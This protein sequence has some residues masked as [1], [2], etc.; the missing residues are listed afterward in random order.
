MLSIVEARTVRGAL[1]TLPLEDI[2]NGY[3]VKEIEG[4]DPVKANVVSSSFARFD[5]SQYQSSRRESRNIKVKLGLELYDVSTSVRDLRN[6]LYQFFMPKSEVS[7]RFYDSDGLT[8]D[9]SGRVESC[10]A[11]LFSSDPQVDVSIICFDPDFTE[12]DPIVVSDVTTNLDTTNPD[13]L[14][15][16]PY[17]GTVETGVEFILHPNRSLTQFSIYHSAYLGGAEDVLD[18]AAPLSAGDTLSISTVPGAKGA[19]LIRGSTSSS[20]LYGISP[21]SAWIQLESGDNYIRF[22]ATGAPIPFDMKYVN[23]YGG[24]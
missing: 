19:T 1:L 22:Y 6:R 7:L 15:Y 2:S 11:P 23:R 9:I 13:G 5:G 21:Q 10:E 18:F 8:V 4:L 12:Q 3:T 17:F 24:L 14:I 16:V 20:M